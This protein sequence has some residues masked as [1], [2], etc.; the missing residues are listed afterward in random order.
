M[1]R[2]CSRSSRLNNFVVAIELQVRL[3][4]PVCAVPTT[5]G[6]RE[7]VVDL[8]RPEC[9]D[10]PLPL[11]IYIHGGGWRQGTQYR[12]PFKPRLFDEGIAVAAIS[13]RFSHEAAFPACLEDCKL[14]VRW[15][16][17]HAEQFGLDPARFA[18]W[19]ISAGGHLASLLGTTNDNPEFEGEGGWRDF[20]SSVGA[21]CTCCGPTDLWRTATDPHP[22]EGMIGLCSDLIGGPLRESEAKARAASPL[23]HVGPHTVPHLFI[24]GEADPIVP[25]AQAA[26]FS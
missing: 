15:L 4:L 7:L 16:R 9:G 1:R 25:M 17:A 12:P 22:G 24:H 14:M 3:D 21:V 26:A 6:Q 13:Y 20:S 11:V 8:Y 2:L 5:T 19:G 18:A 23:Y 10:G